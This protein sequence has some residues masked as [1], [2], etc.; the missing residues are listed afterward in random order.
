MSRRY[1]LISTIVL[2]VVLVLTL[3]YLW[4][5]LCVIFAPKHG[6]VLQQ[7]AMYQGLGVGMLGYW[8]VTGIIQRAGRGGLWCSNIKWMETMSHEMTHAFFVMVLHG[9]VISLNAHDNGGVMSHRGIKSWGHV[10]VS[11]APYCFPL[12]AYLLLALRTMMVLGGMRAFDVLVGVALAFHI[13][14]FA[15]QTG[16]HQTDIRQHP[17]AFSYF[18]ILVCRVVN[19][20]IILVSFWPNMYQRNAGDPFYYGLGM[21]SSAMRWP[22]EM[23]KELMLLIF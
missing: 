23:W 2:A 6:H 17:L 11:L 19:L 21:W 22:V 13:T 4:Y 9:Q 7:L 14:C 5:I 18:Y 12:F 15:K 1:Y 8:L 16:N 10:P 3:P 20:C